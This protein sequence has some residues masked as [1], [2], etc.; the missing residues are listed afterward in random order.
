MQLRQALD[1]CSTALLL[2]IARQHAL[3]LAETAVRAE[4][5]AAVEARLGQP[6]Y[7]TCYLAE[8]PALQRGVLEFVAGAGGE[9]RGYE[10]ER[11]VR[12]RASA[13]P[14]PE[15][16]G[17]PPVQAMEEL[18]PVAAL[19]TSGGTGGPP[20]QGR[21]SAGE[22]GEVV[23][24]LLQRGLLFRAFVPTGPR[25]GETYCLPAEFQPFVLGSQHAPSMAQVLEPAERAGPSL[26]HDPAFSLFLLASYLR[27]TRG[28]RVAQ[29]PAEVADLLGHVGDLTPASHGRFLATLARQSGALEQSGTRLVPTEVVGELL[30][31]REATGGRLWEAFLDC[32]EWN[33]VVESG[34]SPSPLLGRLRDAVELR[35]QALELVRWLDPERWYPVEAVL[36]AIHHVAPDVLRVHYESAS[37]SLLEPR[38]GQILQG[39]DSWAHV[40]A[41]VLRYLLAGPLHWLGIVRWSAD[42]QGRDLVTLTE[43]GAALVAGAPP[44]LLAPVE[45]ARLERDGT[46][47]FPRQGNLAAMYRLET[48]ARLVRRGDPSDYL[49]D[50]ASLCNGLAAGGSLD[51]VI[52]LLAAVLGAPLSER[53][54]QTLSAWAAEYGQASIRPAVLLSVA[55]EQLAARLL[56]APELAPY[57]RSRV[58]PTTAQVAASQVEPL[59]RQLR[60][61][62]CYPALDASLR[63]M[64]S[65]GAYA[66]LVD[67]RTLELLLVSVE[68]LRRLAPTALAE[69]EDVGELRYRLQA[70][71]GSERSR[72]LEAIAR[73][74][75]K[76]AASGQPPARSKGKQPVGRRRR[77][78][79]APGERPES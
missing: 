47:R 39:P 6:E 9:V 48:W 79:P 18:P 14:A 58:G 16:T 21:A 65:R 25:R 41:P 73:R 31:R 15:S 12:H 27:R 11:R 22:P 4:I 2:R 63:L 7:L 17:E 32:A 29:F 75:V 57:L 72:R 67:E 71:L 45:P 34:L 13:A 36:A 35:T 61:L 50:A 70:S 24:D 76:E 49:L 5:A 68:A 1:D 26:E 28:E 19:P 42:A 77:A 46:L 69:L 40:E 33:E 64:A 20:V 44:P 23:L 59:V 38:T 55:D 30:E 3:A 52:R 56:D 74:A 37:A 66:G 62:G 53:V 78:A 10:L 8:L 43:S 60:A 51:D 54:K